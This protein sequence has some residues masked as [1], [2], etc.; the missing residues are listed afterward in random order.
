[1]EGINQGKLSASE[2]AELS[3][4]LQ[5]Q[6]DVLSKEIEARVEQR[7]AALEGTPDAT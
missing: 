5:A 3:A 6:A 2:G 4:I 7:L 1:L